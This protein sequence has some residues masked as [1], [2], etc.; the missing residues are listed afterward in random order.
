MHIFAVA[1]GG[2]HIHCLLPVLQKA[3]SNGHS[4]TILALTTAY[5]TAV[6]SG[7]PT[8]GFADLVECAAPKA[9]QYGDQLSSGDSD[10]PVSAH[11]SRAYTGINYAELVSRLGEVDAASL[12]AREGRRAF[13][14]VEFL[15]AVLENLSPDVVLAT[16]APR[17]ERAA[18]DAARQLGIP[19]VCVCDLFL[20]TELP[21]VAEPAFAD[22][23]CVISEFVMA[24]LVAAGRRRDEISVTGNPAFDRLADETF[25][26]SG[27][28][29]RF[30]LGWDERFVV[31][32]ASQPEP[33]VLTNGIDGDPTRPERWES[34]LIDI[35][36]KSTATGLFVRH[37]P[38]EHR[39]QPCDSESLSVSLQT[40]PVETILQATDAV[41]T[42]SST[43]GLQAAMLGIPVLVGIESPLCV[44][45][46][47][48][49][50]GLAKPVASLEDLESGLEAVRIGQWAPTGRPPPIATAADSVLCEIEKVAGS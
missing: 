6:D 36:A 20:T 8:I 35:A 23:V 39:E 31:T 12:Y 46:P 4:V 25:R 17:A 13:F 1:Y 41:V 33:L 22:R 26:R 44:G 45:A 49:D 30:D 7:L 9:L 15:K 38:S 16:S 37:H 42:F 32:W 28:Q 19:S 5:K 50:M 48:A 40:T 18:I 47:Y 14:P 27:T 21:W 11:E 3:H 24:K 10:G 43:V 29:L 2:G 34:T